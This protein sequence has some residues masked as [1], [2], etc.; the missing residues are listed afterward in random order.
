MTRSLDEPSSSYS[1]I[2]KSYR[3]SDDRLSVEYYI[4]EKAKF[5]NGDQVTAYDVKQ[6][7]DLL[8][9][10]AAHPQ[11]RIY[12][13][14]VDTAMVVDNLTIQF[15]FKRTNPEL[16]MIIGDLPVFSKKWLSAVEFPNNVKKIPIT[17]GPYT[18]SDFSIGKNITYLRN[19]N[20]WAKIY[21][22]ENIC[23]ILIR[24]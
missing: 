17:S 11:Y 18:I 24:L 14:D 2:A 22:L 6:S 9:S 19:K 4:D 1:L 7:F 10:E 3:L 15:T 23:L 13:S 8:V 20:Y 12:W 16:H 21:L 5:S